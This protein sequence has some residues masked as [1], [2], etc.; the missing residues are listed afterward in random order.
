NFSG[1][2]R[3]RRVPSEVMRRN[4]SLLPGSPGTRIFLPS[5]SPKGPSSVSRRRSALR[6]FLSGPWQ[7]K[8]LSARMGRTSRLNSTTFGSGRPP[9]QGG[10]HEPGEGKGTKAER[11]VQVAVHGVRLPWLT[12][13]G[14]G[15]GWVVGAGN[16][17]RLPPDP[18]GRKGFAV[19][20]I[21]HGGKKL[22]KVC[23]G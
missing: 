19:P 23:S 2:M 8:Q 10:E 21:A 11:D 7:A 18:A 6:W 22:T 4:S 14:P 15:M 20:R 16:V 13:G 9:G 5:R 1:G 12:A 3:F 17:S